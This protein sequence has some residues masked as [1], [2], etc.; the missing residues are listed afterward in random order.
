MGIALAPAI[1]GGRHTHQ[2]CVHTV[3]DVTFEDA[4]FDQHVALA[5]VAFI[6]DIERAAPVGQGAVV[7]HGDTFGC[8][9][10]ADA[11]T[12]GAGALAVEI[13]FQPM[14]YSLVQQNAGPARAQYHGH[15]AGWRRPGH[16]VGQGGLHRFVDIAADAGVVKIS[17][18]EAATAA[19]R[20][21][22]ASAFLLG[23]H[24]HRQ[25]H[26]RAHISGQRAVGTGHQHHVVLAGQTGHHLHHARVFAPRELLNPP[27]QRH[28]GGA[29]QAGNGV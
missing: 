12:E 3:L 15:L 7:Q 1:A 5:G 27:Q 22:L 18:A 20:A 8:H 23:N 2:A 19:G 21:H 17:Q 11:A 29:V 28:L 24:R 16:Q 26:Q 6:I 25:A 13:A 4:V 14:T 9:T 10:L